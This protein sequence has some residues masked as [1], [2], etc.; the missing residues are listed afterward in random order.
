LISDF[1]LI[2]FIESKE[3]SLDESSQVFPKVN[4]SY[5]SKSQCRKQVKYIKNFKHGERFDSE[6]KKETKLTKPS[7]LS[8]HVN[9]TISCVNLYEN[10]STLF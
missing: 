8:I 9:K 1:K 2:L 3:E 7:N 10:K 6:F 4:K 5:F